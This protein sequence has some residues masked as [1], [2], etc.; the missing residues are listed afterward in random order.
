MGC[1]L[2]L[3]ESLIKGALNTTIRESHELLS[4]VSVYRNATDDLIDVDLLRATY[5]ALVS[6][7]PHA[8]FINRDFNKLTAESITPRKDHYSNPDNM[9]PLD[10]GNVDALETLG[11]KDFE[12]FKTLI[13]TGEVRGNVNFAPIAVTTEDIHG[14]GHSVTTREAIIIDGNIQGAANKRLV[15]EELSKNLGRPEERWGVFLSTYFKGNLHY[16]MQFRVFIQDRLSDV[17]MRYNGTGLALD[18]NES[19]G[20]LKAM[21]VQADMDTESSVAALENSLNIEDV[22]IRYFNEVLTNDFDYIVSDVFKLI[23]S[24][25]SGVNFEANNIMLEGVHV[26]K[27]FDEVHISRKVPSAVLEEIGLTEPNTGNL[28]IHDGTSG[29][30]A[31]N[32]IIQIKPVE[33]AF[34]RDINGDLFY[35][36]RS[37]KKKGRRKAVRSEVHKLTPDPYYGVKGGAI[38][39]SVSIDHEVDILAQ[40]TEFLKHIFTLFKPIDK[41]NKVSDTRM[42]YYD[43]IR[44]APHLEGYGNTLEAFTDRLREEVSLQT[45]VSDI[46]RGVLTYLI[47]GSKPLGIVPILKSK[48][49][50]NKNIVNAL[51]S[52]LTNKSQT[53]FVYIDNG[54]T[55]VTKR[56]TDKG[57]DYMINDTLAFD[58]LDG[59]TTK[60]YISAALDA[61]PDYVGGDRTHLFIKLVNSGSTASFSIENTMD[62]NGWVD[63]E[64]AAGLA[65]KED[66]LNGGANGHMRALAAE[67]SAI[68]GTSALI[69]RLEETLTKKYGKDRNAVN[70]IL[71]EVA[72][73]TA[74]IASSNDSVV[75]NRLYVQDSAYTSSLFVGVAPAL[76]LSEY[77]DDLITALGPDVTRGEIIAGSRMAATKPTDRNAAIGRQI[78]E[79]NRINKESNGIKITAGPFFDDHVEGIPGATYGYSVIKSP[80]T[81]DDKPIPLSSWN[82]KARFDFAII[83]GFLT[84]MD[85]GKVGERVAL[86]PVTY[87][88]KSAIPMHMIDLDLNI[89]APGAVDTYRKAWYTYQINK[90]LDL[91]HITI[92]K[93][94]KFLGKSRAAILAE[95]NGDANRIQAYNEVLELMRLARIGGR[96]VTMRNETNPTK[97]INY[98]MEKMALPY[99]MFEYSNSTMDAGADYVNIGGITVLPPH[100]GELASQMFN[101]LMSGE[102]QILKGLMAE[103]YLDLKNSGVDEL[104]IEQYLVAADQTASYDE[105]IELVTLINGIYGHG[106]KMITMGDESY[107]GTRYSD[108]SISAYYE[109]SKK[110][111]DKAL[112]DTTA[113]MIAQSKRAQSVLTSGTAYSHIETQENQRRNMS[114][115]NMLHY[116]DVIDGSNFYFDELAGLDLVG[117]EAMGVISRPLSGNKVGTLMQKGNTEAMDSVLVNIGNHRVNIYRDSDPSLNP[118]MPGEHYSAEFYAAIRSMVFKAA[119]IDSLTRSTASTVAQLDM[120]VEDGRKRLEMKDISA[121]IVAL[122]NG[123]DARLTV[124]GMTPMFLL[125]DVESNVDLLSSM[126]QDQENADA[127]QAM[128]PLYEIL[129]KHARGGK[130]SGF[131]SDVSSSLKLVTTTYE[132]GTQRQSLQKK[133]LMMP[134]STEQMTKFGS[135]ETFNI[136]DNM[137]T[138]VRFP[139]TT[140]MLPTTNIDGSFDFDNLISVSGMINMESL[141]EYFG[142]HASND[143]GIWYKVAQSLRH[144]GENMHAFVGLISLPS[145]QKTGRRK[146]SRWEDAT[147]S[148][149]NVP[150]NSKLSI[151][152]MDNTYNYEVLSKKHAYDTTVG[153]PGQ[154][155]LTLLSQLVNAVGFGGLSSLETRTLQNALESLSDINSLNMGS[156]F[157]A[158]LS[159]E[160]RA[161]P[162]GRMFLDGKLDRETMTDA[163]TIAAY[164][165]AI[166]VGVKDLILDTLENGDTNSIIPKILAQEDLGVDSPAA[167]AKILGQVRSSYYKEVIQAKMGGFSGVVSPIH[168]M[169]NI[170]RI[171]GTDRGVS[172]VAYIS[173]MLANSPIIVTESS[174]DHDF[175]FSTP[176]DIIIIKNK[177]NNQEIRM[178]IAAAGGIEMLRDKIKSG[179]MT[180]SVADFSRHP[181]VF[182]GDGYANYPDNSKVRLVSASGKT[183]VVQKWYADEVISFNPSVQYTVFPYVQD[184]RNLRWYKVVDSKGKAK[185]LEDT[186]AYRDLYRFSMTTKKT[187]NS[188]K[189]YEAVKKEKERLAA[190]LV[191][192]T[193]ALNKDGTKKWKLLPPEVVLPTFNAKAF[194]IKK[195]TN[196]HEIIGTS[197]DHEANAVE[198]F[199]KSRIRKF[200]PLSNPLGNSEHDAMI[201]RYKELKMLGATKGDAALDAMYDDIIK[202]INNNKDTLIPN[203]VIND[204]ILKHK[205]RHAKK[206]AASFM[207]SLNVTLTRI[208]GQTKQSGFA[209]IV[210]EFLD[211]QGNATFAPTE[212]L[213]NTGGDFDIDVLSVL[214]KLISS[215]GLYYDYTAFLAKDGSFSKKRV[216]AHFTDTLKASTDSYIRQVGDYNKVLLERLTVISDSLLDPNLDEAQKVLLRTEGLSIRDKHVTAEQQAEGIAKLRKA[217]KTEVE[218]IVMNAAEAGV[219]GAFVDINTAVEVQNPI[220]MDI[221][222][223]IIQQIDESNAEATQG[224]EDDGAERTNIHGLS[225]TAIYYLEHLNA[226]GKEAIGIFATVLKMDSAVQVSRYEYDQREKDGNPDPFIWDFRLDY[227]SNVS[228]KDVTETRSTFADIE[229]FNVLRLLANNEKVQSMVT[230]LEKS[231]KITAANSQELVDA[232]VAEVKNTTE[233]ISKFYEGM[234]EVDSANEVDPLTIERIALA[235]IKSMTG[236]DI[237]AARERAKGDIHLYE[238]ANDFFNTL[239]DC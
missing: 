111:P 165:N 16:G 140:M 206:M 118:K 43:F 116:V 71:M 49:D 125:S 137:N 107:F 69:I 38:I 106:L 135:P 117:L 185:S 142:G 139:T 31:I 56:V 9:P 221:F 164:D 192:E 79:I 23:Q 188:V 63:I 86:Q 1:K 211:A 177:G 10:A 92:D 53:Q 87:S 12:A 6:V 104:E 228:N 215:E 239:K 84:M 178:S 134:F 161:G 167:R 183:M 42:S 136:L 112:M 176:R 144:T 15:R 148:S 213:V 159:E 68:T 236:L 100:T 224:K 57:F 119:E 37:R 220:S 235:K 55:I 61:R 179:A 27:G 205:K 141:F 201:T 5:T 160:H 44:L 170:F 115:D 113:M 223:G 154:A 147:G 150:G 133:A 48:G 190:N 83:Q 74:E 207:E 109:A 14:V 39:N 3:N 209:G 120:K 163:D 46:A 47:D 99:G 35:T 138:A 186:K 169:I 28:V 77:S 162:L 8:R 237:E 152:Y 88:D 41:N 96:D 124:A 72:I 195:G 198:W 108:A 114:D 17:I 175:R 73:K 131:D 110:D 208:P 24:E 78:P 189:A 217:I 227:H 226:Q 58:M 166:R 197:G 146:K 202:A 180:V 20:K 40:D 121:K 230:G 98:L 172:R 66:A 214:T 187:Q 216:V 82:P 219:R 80:T 7:K 103:T 95:F 90:N 62:E 193:Q 155:K 174:F 36:T 30:L 11:I 64:K 26:P 75:E 173:H 182:E 34:H 29:R 130:L 156:I 200:N 94:Y 132:Y 18:V 21:L 19:V 97:E 158:A 127:S 149:G 32:P 33:G 232:I 13:I 153:I 51:T 157:H 143:P 181:P 2:K 4:F 212:H 25:T 70:T 65:A 184:A 210:I 218:A 81:V 194:G 89:F 171:P 122:H 229:R 231:G 22:R 145:G 222:L 238:S 128:H 67:I 234:G 204:V 196:L 126:G 91:Q 93:V 191:R 102:Q 151:D 54:K 59:V 60:H 105:F 233:S 225:W 168:D 85:K 101:D 199:T 50:H 45:P 52:A 129:F 76:H 123:G 203:R